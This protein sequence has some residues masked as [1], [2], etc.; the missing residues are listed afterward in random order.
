MKWIEFAR[1]GKTQ[2]PPHAVFGRG[3]TTPQVSNTVGIRASYLGTLGSI[4]A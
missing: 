3:V 4:I 2:Q 1:R